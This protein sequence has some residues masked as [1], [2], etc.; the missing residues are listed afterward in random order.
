MAEYAAERPPEPTRHEIKMGFWKWTQFRRFF[1]AEALGIKFQINFLLK[2]RMF[3]LRLSVRVIVCFAIF[4]MEIFAI[5][6]HLTDIFIISFFYA[7]DFYYGC[8]LDSLTSDRLTINSL[9]YSEVVS[10]N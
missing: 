5:L 2:T 6:I 3:S 8:V 1:F 9:W 7:K 4:L 10:M